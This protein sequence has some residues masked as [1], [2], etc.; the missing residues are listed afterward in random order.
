MLLIIITFVLLISGVTGYI[1]LIKKPQQPK[2]VE[3]TQPVVAEVAKE[4][5]KEP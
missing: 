5:V 1:F 3:L 2:K 4:K